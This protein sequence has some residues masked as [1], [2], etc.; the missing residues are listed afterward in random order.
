MTHADRTCRAS[1]QLAVQGPERSGVSFIYAHCSPANRSP[2]SS[3]LDTTPVNSYLKGTSLNRTSLNP[4]THRHARR[5]GPCCSRLT[6][7]ATSHDSAKPLGLD[8]ILPL[9]A[10]CRFIRE[11]A[12][13]RYVTWRSVTSIA[14]PFSVGPPPFLWIFKLPQPRTCSRID[15]DCLVPCHTCSTSPCRVSD[16]IKMSTS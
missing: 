4:I 16:K 14:V 1:L 3:C 12:C 15:V 10:Q 9:F 11:R 7:A 6:V 13:W 8:E 2:I 5:A